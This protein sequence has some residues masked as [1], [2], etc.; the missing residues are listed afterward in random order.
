MSGPMEKMVVYDTS[1]VILFV[2]VGSPGFIGP[3]SGDHSS[4]IV[5]PDTVVASDTHYVAGGN[6]LQRGVLTPAVPR[7]TLA[8]DGV[9]SVTIGGLPDPCVITV[10]GA[11]SFG[12]AVV[13]GG[14]GTISTN[15]VGPIVVRV[16]ADPLFVPWEV[17]LDA[18]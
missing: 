17:T 8:A 12:P 1:G 9:D 2:S 14:G 3:A 15:A 18:H 11:V 5:S 6:L 10:T 4:I 7:T 16:T 13:T